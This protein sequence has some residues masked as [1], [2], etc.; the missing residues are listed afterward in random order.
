MY[1]ESPPNLQLFVLKTLFVLD[2]G[3]KQSVRTIPSIL[4]KGV[5]LKKVA[6][7]EGQKVRIAKGPQQQKTDQV[8]KPGKEAVPAGGEICT[9]PVRS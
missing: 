3:E 2:A 7:A 4:K 5:D 9:R 6:G 8:L 1:N